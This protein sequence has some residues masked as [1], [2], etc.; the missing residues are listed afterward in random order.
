[1]IQKYRDC[2]LSR[3][4]LQLGQASIVD[5]RTALAVCDNHTESIVLSVI[6]QDSDFKWRMVLGQSKAAEGWL[7]RGIPSAWKSTCRHAMHKSITLDFLWKR[8]NKVKNV[9]IRMTEEMQVSR[10]K[11]CNIKYRRTLMHCTVSSQFK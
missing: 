6:L 4:G 10:N 3:V 11:M 9:V 2:R 8:K 7:K 1:L 5:Q